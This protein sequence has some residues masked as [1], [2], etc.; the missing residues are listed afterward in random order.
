MGDSHEITP[1][2]L[3]ETQDR[4]AAAQRTE[5]DDPMLEA[6]DI[7]RSIAHVQE[8]LL[9]RDAATLYGILVPLE[10]F[11]KHGIGLQLYFEFLKEMTIAFMLIACI[12]IIPFFKNWE[13][14]WLKE[15]DTRIFFD[16]FTLAN[17]EGPRAYDCLKDVEDY[18]DDYEVQQV[19]VAYSDMAYTIIFLLSLAIFR[20]RSIQMIARYQEANVTAAHYSVVVKGLPP[21]T[22]EEEV[23]EHFATKYGE[24][25]EVFLSRKDTHFLHLYKR[26]AKLQ[27]EQKKLQALR[28]LGAEVSDKNILHVAEQIARM[29]E[30][31]EAQVKLHK[32]TYEEQEVDRAFII[33]NNKESRDRCLKDYHRYSRFCCRS[34]HQPFSLRFRQ[35]EHI[36]KVQEAF[37]PST[38]RWQ[39][40]NRGMLFKKTSRIIIRMIVAGMLI[41]S[42][43]FLFYLKSTDE[44]L[45]NSHECEKKDIDYD[46]S[47]GEIKEKYENDKDYEDKKDCWCYGQKFKDLVEDPDNND[48]CE[49]YLEALGKSATNRVF[50]CI[51]LLLINFG[52]EFFMTK[53]SKYERHSSM[54]AEKV[55]IMTKI[56]VSTF[57]NTALISLLVNAD[58]Q[59][60]KFVSYL[61]FKDILLE[62]E[63]SDFN[64]FWYVKV[65]STF[66]LTMAMSVLVPHLLVF[67]LLYPFKKCRRRGLC[68]KQGRIRLQEDLNSTLEGTEFKIEE[69]NAINLNII[70]TCFMYSGGMPILNFICFFALA[71]RFWIDK[72]LV[73]RFYK[74]PPIYDEALNN[75]ALLLLPFSVMIHCLVSMYM[76]GSPTIFPLD[77]H[78]EDDATQNKE[79]C[80]C[81][82]VVDGDCATDGKCVAV[83]NK[84]LLE[85]RM[86][87]DI[88]VIFL[89]LFCFALGLFVLD[90]ALYRLVLLLYKLIYRTSN[91]D[92]GA[93]TKYTDQVSKIAVRSLPTYD[94]YKNPKYSPAVHA[95]NE[96]A[97]KF[98]QIELELAS[99]IGSSTSRRLSIESEPN[100]TPPQVFLTQDVSKGL[101]N[102]SGGSEEK[103][104]LYNNSP[105]SPVN[106]EE[107]AFRESY[108]TRER[109]LADAEKILEDYGGVESVESIIED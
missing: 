48:F 27:K 13:G 71:M 47:P 93:L 96:I 32:Q 30:K 15:G 10:E 77:M 6:A 85:D 74:K 18:E 68:L 104:T 86:S 20:V 70:Y 94:I 67:G 98:K 9:R 36:L 106:T 29:H 82:F 78:C 8:T 4:S 2:L 45:P 42:I 22:T 80:D 26:Y 89:I 57:I 7:G 108:G 75:R 54:S 28:N 50:T 21:D 63:F 105:L 73:L 35:Q 59:S 101:L 19:K 37:E 16:K 33:F 24:I 61:P 62:T 44:K 99:Q 97:V 23:R 46:K 14:S 90:F 84:M 17:Q 31:L 69:D 107:V 41:L 103:A 52:L 76:Y 56:F 102:C 72:L 49:E 38:I 60:W 109:A 65:G 83:P 66:V 1:H 43:T 55:D 53:L 92:P 88:G 87:S 100:I 25:V 51:A 39:N 40:L 5:I 11:G 81:D 34:K 95:M 79:R 12:S 91:L 3:V 58:L 64:R